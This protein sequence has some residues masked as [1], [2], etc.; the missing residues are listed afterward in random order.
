MMLPV[1]YLLYERHPV[2]MDFILRAMLLSESSHQFWSGDFYP[3]WLMD[4]NAGLGSPVMLFQPNLSTYFAAVFEFLAP[5]DPHGFARV[6]ILMSLFLAIG[7]A[8]CFLWLKESFEERHAQSGAFLYVIFPLQIPTLYSIMSPHVTLAIALFPW[9][10]F[11]ARKM[12]NEPV[13][14]F[15]YYS[16][17]QAGLALTS[18]WMTII[19]SAVPIA[20][21]LLFSEQRQRIKAT[22]M[23]TLAVALGCAVAAVYW[24]PL[25]INK[26]FILYEEFTKDYFRYGQN[27]LSIFKSPEKT[28]GMF[29]HPWIAFWVSIIPLIAAGAILKKDIFSF[30]KR[31]SLFFLGVMAVAILMCFSI[32]A[33]LWKLLPFLENIQFP[34]R[35]MNLA[36]PAAVFVAVSWLPRIKNLSAFYAAALLTAAMYFLY[37]GNYRYVTELNPY[38]SNVVAHKLIPQ[39]AHMTVWMQKAGIVDPLNPPPRYIDVAPSQV[40]NGAAG[41]TDLA[42]KSRVIRFKADVSTPDATVVLKRYYYPG[43]RS[44]KEI[45]GITVQEQGAL[46]AVKLP[47]GRYEVTLKQPWFPGEKTGVL[48]SSIALI[49]I[50][51]GSGLHRYYAKRRH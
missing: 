19:F 27:F 43:W 50:M 37:A 36:I 4:V 22:L 35:F 13:R 23:I 30:R 40:V 9:M 7:G 12:L 21:V 26:E 29:F 32:S 42:Q 44:P 45:P 6:I 48:I 8:G 51:I 10:L 25:L 46:L 33:F 16:L 38:W 11:V 28:E 39:N 24:Y 14:Y 41:I 15:P 1:W 34:I 31:E 47:R 17:L 49:I 20:Y 3:R 18:L 5:L 2:W